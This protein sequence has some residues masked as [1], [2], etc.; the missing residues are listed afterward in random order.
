MGTTWAEIISNYTMPLITDVRLDE[1]IASNPAQYFRKMQFYLQSGIPSFKRP[2]E[3][4]R[5]LEDGLVFPKFTDAEWV[6]T[7]ASM[8]QETTVATGKAGYELFSC[9]LVQVDGAGTTYY[10]PYPGPTY[11][12]ET[13]NVVF[14]AQ[15]TAGLIYTMDFYKDGSFAHDLTLTQKRILG[16][17]TAEVWYEPITNNWLNMQ[18]K[19]S[20]KSSDTKAE[21]PNI[22]A[23]TARMREVKADLN[24]ALRSYEQD[25]AINTILPNRKVNLI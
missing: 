2:P 12:A 20:D 24:A 8:S 9:S 23:M 10:I 15:S 1:L 14:P 25:C 21:A 13:G 19:N 16:L 18:P 4:R 7:D 17:C 22:Q 3:V 11:D 5:Y 6:S